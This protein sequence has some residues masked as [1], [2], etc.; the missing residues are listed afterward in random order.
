MGESQDPQRRPDHP[1]IHSI[2]GLWLK[3]LSLSKSPM[4]TLRFPAAAAE[5]PAA[6]REQP[7]GGHRT[8]AGAQA[9]FR[10]LE[11]VGK[12]G[13][14]VVYQA[15]QASLDRKVAIKR[16]RP[17]Q[18]A[19]PEGA[20]RFVREAEL[21]GRLE[22]PNIIP[23]H[24]LGRDEEGLLFYTMKLVEGRPWSEG[25]RDHPLEVNLGILARVMDA[26]AFAHARG[27]VHRDLKPENVMLG[28]FGEVYV[29]D[30]GLASAQLAPGREGEDALLLIG[31]T[32]AYMA[33][34][35][36]SG[37]GPFTAPAVDIYLLGAILFEI[38][39]GQTPHPGERS[40][41]VFEFATRN[42]LTPTPVKGELMDIALKAM[43][44]DPGDRFASVHAL[45]EA[46]QAYKSHVESRSLA[47]LA[48]KAAL[49][50]ARDRAYSSFQGAVFGFREALRL[51]PENPVAREALPRVLAEYA[52]AACARGDLDLAASLLEPADAGHQ[53]LLGRVLAA[54]QQR[55]ARQARLRALTAGFAVL[56]AALLV[57]L[58]V[59]VVLIK[60]QNERVL[61]AHRAESRQLQAAEAAHYGL[62][63]TQVV[64]LAGEGKGARALDLLRSLPTGPRGWEWGLLEAR[65]QAG[66]GLAQQVFRGHAGA[67][68]YLA[69]SPDGRLAAS[70]GYDRKVLVWETAGGSLVRTFQGAGDWRGAGALAFSPDGLL[71]LGDG[72]VWDPAG[73]APRFRLAGPLE[74][75]AALAFS[76]DGQLLAGA[77]RDG[78]LR[79]WHVPGGALAGERKEGPGPITR[80]AFS[81]DGSLLLRG[82]QDGRVHLVRVQPS[83]FGPEAPRPLQA[84]PGE[85]LATAWS[86][87]GAIAAG[88]KDG[89]VRAWGPTGKLWWSQASPGGSV[90]ALAFSPDG[91]WLAGGSLDGVVRLWSAASGELALELRGHQGKVDPVAFG[92]DGRLFTGSHDG[93]V[94]VWRLPRPEAGPGAQ[95]PVQ[96]LVALTYLDGSRLLAA[97]T[98]GTLT[99]WDR[100]RDQVRWTAH[101]PPGSVQ[102]LAVGP[103]Q[104]RIYTAGKDGVIR[105]WQA[106]DGQLQA[107]WPGDGTERL[108]LAVSGEL[109]A[110]ADKGHAVRVLRA[111]T[112]E[113]VKELRGPEDWVGAL[114]F[115]PDG[116]LLAAASVAG[117]LRVWDT[118]TWQELVA[119]RGA[120]GR[121]LNPV[122]LGFAPGGEWLARGAWDKAIELLDPATGKVL[123][124][125]EGQDGWGRG[126]WTQDGR[127]YVAASVDG[128]FRVWD[129][130]TG[131]LLVTLALPPGQLEAMALGPDGRSV[132]LGCLG[133]N[134]WE[135][136]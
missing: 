129:P 84:L 46:I 39:T 89:T 70:G 36:A 85:V 27:V 8:L 81:P 134:V 93:T 38:L 7:L 4:K 91:R 103:R 126:A 131:S 77:G 108:A 105:V 110:V 78:T 133:L 32:P 94:R 102:A 52:L 79:L 5:A 10:I 54:R 114:A 63:I 121:T 47:A 25:M 17:E 87:D 30:W 3:A 15:V 104:T 11:A 67:V 69:L 35:I 109:L 51:W 83:G 45:Q 107:E 59:A 12:G 53:A 34:E 125:L 14:G 120:E 72:T 64:A 33:P 106:L 49:E 43:A 40:T 29:M 13:M 20:L 24:E 136:D 73:Q 115:S 71:A 118:R 130:A 86:R 56:G 22:H 101:P 88:A 95:D 50:A 100:F 123:R 99:C 68:R 28:E 41:E 1:E 2:P 116:Q 122:S 82:A 92:A 61:V 62:G 75:L 26:T 76:P 74:D 18:A 16:V 117:G 65:I 6:A 135:A 58:T 124:R 96:P 42:V 98:D 97:R 90:P 37:R 119:Q 19:D 80:L 57:T 66:A 55:R 31:G 111:G 128:K 44:M 21:T 48:A 112:G 9:E 132:A 23:I 113:P 127:R 60:R